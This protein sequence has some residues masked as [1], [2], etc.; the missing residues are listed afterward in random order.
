VDC[1][2][3]ETVI[4]VDPLGKTERLSAFENQL[5]GVPLVQIKDDEIDLLVAEANAALAIAS[6]Y[7]K[8]WL[9]DEEIAENVFAELS[10]PPGGV[11]FDEDDYC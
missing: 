1:P 9:T 2:Y 4:E 5:I 10:L 6:I 7:Q 8:E 3:A 11:L